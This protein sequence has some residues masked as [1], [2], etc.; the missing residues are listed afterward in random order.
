M[1]VPN[2]DLTL[3]A[4]EIFITCMTCVV[5]VVDLYLQ[6]S[7]R[8]IS[9][10]LAQWTLLGTLLLTLVVHGDE[11]RT[12]FGGQFV[13]DG[14]ADVLKTFIYLIVAGVFLYSRPYL[15]DRRPV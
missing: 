4:P 9:Y 8:N 13:Q 11:P 10:W 12:T 2:L 1:N 7:R 14:M 6:D 3:V 5:L 15:K